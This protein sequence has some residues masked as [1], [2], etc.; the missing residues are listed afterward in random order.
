MCCARIAVRTS[1]AGRVWRH[2]G[3]S[4]H[5]SD[6]EVHN[7]RQK[8]GEQQHGART[9]DDS[10]RGQKKRRSQLTRS[11]CVSAHVDAARGEVR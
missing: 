11:S 4:S 3:T 2:C 8:T 6:A 10:G 9:A 1:A 7:D 5:T